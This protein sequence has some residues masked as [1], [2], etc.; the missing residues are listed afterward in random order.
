MAVTERSV[1]AYD[2][3]ED[4]NN[5]MT[6]LKR[7]DLGYGSIQEK[8]NASDV[9]IA[10]L[11]KHPRLKNAETNLIIFTVIDDIDERTTP[12]S[13]TDTIDEKLLGGVPG[14]STGATEETSGV[15]G[16]S[17]GST[18]TPVQQSSEPAVEHTIEE[19]A[20]AFFNI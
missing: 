17:N 14:T 5:G 16:I 13:T 9:N 4:L 1:S 20:D 12:V 7:D 11:R 10:T 19:S 18:E 2:I 6:W 3:I 15:P 8:Y